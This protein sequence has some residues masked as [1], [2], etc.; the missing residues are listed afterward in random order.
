MNVPEAPWWVGQFE[1][2]IGLIKASLCRT[3]GK[4]QLTWA[5]LEEVL[6]DIGIILGKRSLTCIEE[7]IDYPVL[8]PNSLILGHDVNFPDA[9]PHESKSESDISISNHVKRFY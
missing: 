9:A 1:W 3:I 2:L 5:E 6:L 8:T 4:A 7:E